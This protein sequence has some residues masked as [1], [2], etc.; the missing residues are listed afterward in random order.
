M[1]ERLTVSLEDGTL[2]Q[3]RTLAGGQRKVGAYLSQLVA[4]LWD[5]KEDLDA[6]GLSGCVILRRDKVGDLLG[7]DAKTLAQQI[8]ETQARL[9]ALETDTHQITQEI[10]NEYATLKVH[11][12]ELER[13]LAT[14]ENSG[15]NDA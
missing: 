1:S 8:E 2:E 4:W 10:R 5:S 11:A 15:S 13:R 6:V 3:L 7:A 9:Q 12:L 14:Q